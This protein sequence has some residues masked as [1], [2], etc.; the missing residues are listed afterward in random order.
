[1]SDLLARLARVMG[2]GHELASRI[3]AAEWHWARPWVA[4]VG[5]ALLLPAA[6]WIHRRHAE[7]HPWLAPRLRLLLDACRVGTLALLVF[8]LRVDQPRC[9]GLSAVGTREDRVHPLL[10]AVV[11]APGTAARAGFPA[12]PWRDR[13]AAC[14]AH[15]SRAGPR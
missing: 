11:R 13:R 9:C 6:W 3:D 2:I 7:R 4:W 1:M 5:F 12:G 10:R 14:R 15:R 8:V